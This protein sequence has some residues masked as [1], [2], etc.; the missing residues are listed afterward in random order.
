[1]SI[2]VLFVITDSVKLLIKIKHNRL[3]DTLTKNIHFVFNKDFD[4]LK[5]KTVITGVKFLQVLTKMNVC[6]KL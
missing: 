4:V 2:T 6:K 1:M 5:K 3:S